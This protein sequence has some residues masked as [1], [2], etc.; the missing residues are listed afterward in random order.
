M[1]PQ[2]YA[3]IPVASK[4]SVR[5]VLY[6]ELWWFGNLPIQLPKR[7]AKVVFRLM[8]SVSSLDIRFVAMII[9]R[10]CLS[11]HGEPQFFSL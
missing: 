8:A 3:T 4:R 7:T 5:R 2:I 1:T 10:L 6:D 9:G 11:S